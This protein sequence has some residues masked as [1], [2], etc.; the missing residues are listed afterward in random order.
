MATPLSPNSWTPQTLAA[1]V[2][3]NSLV[4]SE[5]TLPN[6]SLALSISES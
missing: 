6:I 2:K 4:N 3:S 5:Q 1:L